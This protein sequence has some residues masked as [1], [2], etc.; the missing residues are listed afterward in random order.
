MDSN[1]DIFKIKTNN[2]APQKGK[3]LI[4]EPFLKG[5]YFNRSIIFLADHGENG[6][7]GFIL[8]KPFEYPLP[9]FKKQF[10][11][12]KGQIYIGGPVNTESLYYIHTLGNFIPGSVHIIDNLYWGGDFE[13]LKDLINTGLVNE[14]QV[15]FF[16]GYSGWEKDQLVEEVQDN[17][18]LVSSIS[19]KNV[20]GG[21]KHLWNKMV[22][23]V[24][25]QYLLW[26]NY[27]Q[28]PILN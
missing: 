15:R 2:I 21:H 8:N 7:V 1:F 25:G 19:E 28:N 22:K 11:E 17:S 14:S 3:I 26:E 18:W 27:P 16:V 6:S 9:S 4:A 20:L 13:H 23:E 12:F 10:P 24:G 5:S